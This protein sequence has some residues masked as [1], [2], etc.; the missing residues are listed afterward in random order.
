M[1]LPFSLFHHSSCLFVPVDVVED[2][3]SE[4]DNIPSNK[5]HPNLHLGTDYQNSPDTNNLSFWGVNHSQ[6]EQSQNN[7]EDGFQEGLIIA[8]CLCQRVGYGISVVSRL[9]FT[10][11]KRLVSRCFCLYL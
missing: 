1:L 7:Q 9:L 11:T 2:D 3:R 10:W 4:D 5:R 8:N 6:N